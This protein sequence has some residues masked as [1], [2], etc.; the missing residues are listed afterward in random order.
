MRHLLDSARLALSPRY[1]ARRLPEPWQETLARGVN[2]AKRRSLVWDQA[3]GR[4]T[5]FHITHWKAGSQWIKA[6]LNGLAYRR[7][8]PNL[9]HQEQLFEQPLRRG[10]IYAASYVSRPRFE[11]LDVPADHRA[12]VVIR[13]LRDALVSYYFSMRYSHPLITDYVRQ[14]REDLQGVQAEEGMLRLLSGPLTHFARIQRS[15]LDTGV[16]IFRYEDLL[17]DTTAVLRRMA[18]IAELPVSERRIRAV[19]RLNAFERMSGGRRRGQENPRSFFRKGVAGDW[20]AHFTPAITRAFKERY[21][22]LLVQTG[23]E[24]DLDW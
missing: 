11:A 12:F 7:V 24:T 19:V 4:P 8:M 6:L 9:P 17:G 21:G 20:R 13:D 15:W 2:E 1:L 18:R 10:A 5:V 3:L 23:Y 22:E 16:E 14:R